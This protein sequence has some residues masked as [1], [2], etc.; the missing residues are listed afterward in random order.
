[1][2]SLFLKRQKDTLFC[3][4]NSLLKGEDW[5]GNSDKTFYM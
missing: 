2:H 3:N 5:K 1:M 4:K